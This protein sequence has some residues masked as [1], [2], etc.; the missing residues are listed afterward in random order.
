MWINVLI[1]IMA[2]TGKEFI[3]NFSNHI[4]YILAH[5]ISNQLV[6]IMI[7]ILNLSYTLIIEVNH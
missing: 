7:I 3:S 6:D 1:Y 4:L 2:K 5:K